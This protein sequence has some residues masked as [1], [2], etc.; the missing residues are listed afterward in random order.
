MPLVRHIAQ[1]NDLLTDITVGAVNGTVAK[2][3]DPG[4]HGARIPRQNSISRTAEPEGQ[5]TGQGDVVLVETAG[6]FRQ[7]QIDIPFG[8]SRAPVRRKG[9]GPRHA[10]LVEQGVEAV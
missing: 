7:V 4:M 3:C 1:R 10:K 2:A 5:A 6:V 8:S 9:E